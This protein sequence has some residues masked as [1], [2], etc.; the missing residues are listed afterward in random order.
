MPHDK[1]PVDI[2][3]QRASQ[4]CLVVSQGMGTS[5]GPRG[6]F[7][8]QRPSALLGQPLGITSSTVSSNRD[9]TRRH[10]QWCPI[11]YR[12]PALSTFGALSSIRLD[13]TTWYVCG[14]P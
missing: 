2:L 10:R 11:T 1:Y 13:V 7:G 3:D 14:S 12:W 5:P 6:R 9:G 8:Q 4:D